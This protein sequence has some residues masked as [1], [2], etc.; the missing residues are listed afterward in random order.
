ML[1]RVGEVTGVDYDDHALAAARSRAPAV[2]VI[3]AELPALPFGDSSFDYVVSFET[4]EHISDAPGFV[5]EMARVLEPAGTLLISTPNGGY[6][7]GNNPWH[8]TEYSLPDFV[9]LLKGSGFSAISIYGQ[10]TPADLSSPLAAQAYRV[11]ARFPRLCRPGRWWDD[12]VH[13]SSKVARH[14]GPREPLFWVVE[15]RSSRTTGRRHHHAA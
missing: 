6:E 10:R 13:G 9:T 12:L 1:S 11:M 4:I 2:S 7:M 14:L 8:V 5:V 15:A 3:K